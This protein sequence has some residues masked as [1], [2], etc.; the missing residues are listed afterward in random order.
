MEK[1]VSPTDATV[2]R[3]EERI[4]RMESDSKTETSENG[5]ASEFSFGSHV[6]NVSEFRLYKDGETVECTPSEIRLLREAQQVWRER[7]NLFRDD[8]FGFN[9]FIVS[10]A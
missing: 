5:S 6:L 4:R 1:W 2:L 10:A 9:L 7:Y 8:A 3:R